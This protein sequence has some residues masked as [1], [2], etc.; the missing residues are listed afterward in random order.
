MADP[1]LRAIDRQQTACTLYAL[2]SDQQ[3]KGKWSDDLHGPAYQAKFE[4]LCG[5][6]K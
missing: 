6:W 3:T 2:R 1:I 5:R 4:A